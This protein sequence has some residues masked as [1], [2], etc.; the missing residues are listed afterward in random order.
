MNTRVESRTALPSDYFQSVT[1]LSI[2]LE[3]DEG[4]RRRFSHE[5]DLEKPCLGGTSPQP[6]IKS[7][8]PAIDHV[9]RAAL[10]HYSYDEEDMSSDQ[11][12]AQFSPISLSPQHSNDTH[13]SEDTLVNPSP[14]SSIP[15]SPSSRTFKWL[16][17]THRAFSEKAWQT[18][19]NTIRNDE[20]EAFWRAEL[21]WIEATHRAEKAELRQ[22][23]VA[24]ASSEGLASRHHTISGKAW[25]S[26]GTVLQSEEA[27]SS[28]L[29]HLQWVQ[30][31]HKIETAELRTELF[32]AE[33]SVKARDVELANDH[34]DY[35]A[36]VNALKE[37]HDETKLKLA[38][39][40]EEL[41]YAYD[42]RR[43]TQRKTKDLRKDNERSQREVKIWEQRTHEA[44]AIAE[45]LRADLDHARE[46]RDR[47]I[48]Q[49][50]S[51]QM[52]IAQKAQ[53]DLL[54]ATK[55][56][57]EREK[58]EFRGALEFAMAK[59]NEKDEEIAKLH[60]EAHLAGLEVDYIHA[61]NTGYRR[62]TEDHP[63]R[64]AHLDGL[65]KRKDEAYNDLLE[66]YKQCILRR[67]EEEKMRN[68]DR[69]HFSG[70]LATLRREIAALNEEMEALGSSRDGFQEQNEDILKM[71]ERKV[72]S[73]DIV[74][75]MNEEFD[76]LKHDNAFLIQKVRSRDGCI[77]ERMA[78]ITLLKVE[79]IHFEARP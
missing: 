19:A 23:L 41:R 77:E 59:Q 12:L 22:K 73:E 57:L 42:R 56:K 30:H 70:T 14:Q 60:M 54:Q 71:F 36:E 35:Q 10:H 64:S 58:Q 68:V 8:V 37:E 18:Y 33:C 45:S 43:E 72:F 67:A 49:N 46:E 26:Y 78:E 34:D 24:R 7:S 2:I 40:D 62:D 16:G 39:R 17:E 38:E 51:A 31:L 75:A 47:L 32:S 66:R 76:I 15:S 28:W 65:L 44:M 50:D 21:Q 69:E 55:Q 53:I 63:E 25:R 6:F 9:S 20:L 1:D 13:S 11:P 29:M 79:T 61:L 27:E 52:I 74:R 3:F 48:T 4:E 5:H